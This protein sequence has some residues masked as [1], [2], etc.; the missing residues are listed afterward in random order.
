[1]VVVYG[2]LFR[3]CL[4]NASFNVPTAWTE[5]QWHDMVEVYKDH[6]LEH[7]VLAPVF[8]SIHMALIHQRC[9]T[10]NDGV[11]KWWLRVAL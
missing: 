10:R 7:H 6:V 9:D 11:L 8:D 4:V 5:R 2:D 3:Q 1:M